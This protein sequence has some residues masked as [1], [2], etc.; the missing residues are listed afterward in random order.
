MK[1]NVLTNLLLLKAKPTIKTGI[2]QQKLK[3]HIYLWLY[4]CYSIKNALATIEHTLEAVSSW[5][6]TSTHNTIWIA[7]A[8]IE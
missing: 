3:L 4:R 6:K 5:A 8:N 7:I 1:A 2:T